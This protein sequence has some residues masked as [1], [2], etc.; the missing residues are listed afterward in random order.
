LLALTPWSLLRDDSGPAL[1]ID[2]MDRSLSAW[3]FR[4]PL[5][6]GTN[7]LVNVQENL[8]VCVYCQYCDNKISNYFYGREDDFEVKDAAFAIQSIVFPGDRKSVG[9]S[10]CTIEDRERSGILLSDK[11]EF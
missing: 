9:D 7:D 3:V 5:H 2:L 1:I 6:F 10:R 8:D 4:S 11:Q